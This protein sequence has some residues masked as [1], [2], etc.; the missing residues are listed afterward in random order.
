MPVAY[1]LEQFCAKL[2]QLIRSHT[3]VHMAQEN[4][5]TKKLNPHILRFAEPLKVQ[6]GG[7][8]KRQI[9]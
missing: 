2:P 4:L 9:W 6:S 8:R 1:V 5:M 3:L 7:L